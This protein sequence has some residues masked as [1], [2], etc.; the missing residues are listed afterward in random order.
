MHICE[1]ALLVYENRRDTPIWRVRWVQGSLDGVCVNRLEA[2][3]SQWDVKSYMWRLCPQVTVDTVPLNTVGV[4]VGVS[5][6]QT[7]H[8][9]VVKNTPKRW[10]VTR[11]LWKWLWLLVAEHV[12][13][14]PRGKD[15]EPVED[16]RSNLLHGVK[17]GIYT[18][19]FFIK[20]FCVSRLTPSFG[21]GK[22]KS[23]G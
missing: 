20:V 19:N 12:H 4:N 18:V 21:I 13:E 5:F 2:M 3:L 22:M 17:D 14:G 8:L 11:L 15:T 16:C 6:S 10:L 23:K 7:S 9:T 1:T